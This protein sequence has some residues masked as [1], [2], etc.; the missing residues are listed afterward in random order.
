[1]IGQPILSAS[2]MARILARPGRGGSAHT[3][4]SVPDCE[5]ALWKRPLDIGA[6]MW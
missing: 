6:I 2:R 1:M 5:I 3:F 4:I